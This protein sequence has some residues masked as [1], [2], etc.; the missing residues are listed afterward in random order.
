MTCFM[1]LSQHY[2]RRATK[3]LNHEPTEHR[4][5][6]YDIVTETGFHGRLKTKIKVQFETLMANKSAIISA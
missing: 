5:L 3:D 1:V 4:L 6:T 2:L